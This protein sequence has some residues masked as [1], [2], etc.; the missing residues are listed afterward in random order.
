VLVGQVAQSGLRFV[1]MVLV[2]RGLGAATL[3]SFG[4]VMNV[5]HFTQVLADAGLPQS[6]LKYIAACLAQGDQAGARATGRLTALLSL[7]FTGTLFAALWLLAPV[8]SRAGGRPDLLV[9]LRIA[10]L[11]VPLISITGT[12][13]SVEQARRNVWPLVLISRSG[14]PALFLAATAFVV[15]QRGPV[16]SLIW[17]YV[18]AAAAGLLASLAVFARWLAGLD[19]A[20]RRTVGLREVVGYSTTMWA[21]AI[22]A[23]II[24]MADVFVLGRFV[25]PG[26]LGVYVAAARTAFFVS[27]PLFAMNALYAPVVSDLH[28]RGDM[29]GLR[30]A[31]VTT[32]R[33]STGAALAL[34]GPMVIA[35]AVVVGAFG[36]EFHAGGALLI[37]LGLGQLVNSATGGVA[38]MLAMTGGQ[39]IL[40]G[41]NWACAAVLAGGLVLASRHWGAIG[42]AACVG[43]VVAAVNIVRLVWVWRRLR[44][45]PFDARYWLCWLVTAALIGALTVAS[46]LGGYPVALGSLGLFAVGFALVGW[47]GWLARENPLAMRRRGGLEA[48]PLVDAGP[49]QE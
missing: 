18:L 35:P 24:S 30:H 13:L 10:A 45:H 26:E 14:V 42:A 7:G 47:H 32:T 44:L 39:A 28:A 41:T 2:G 33:W 4:W 12:L 29:A 31:Y 25:S 37:L 23:S 19:S 8:V 16:T 9:P 49:T 48:D 17:A 15:W 22:A 11:V 6:N 20:P 36:R 46:R 3:G 40:A 38:W 5:E 1:T 21:S 43:T 34:F 27:F